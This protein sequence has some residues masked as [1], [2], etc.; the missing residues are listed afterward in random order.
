[1]LL[2]PLPLPWPSARWCPACL[3][4]RMHPP[5]NASTIPLPWCRLAETSPHGEALF[6]VAA[7]LRVDM[8]VGNTEGPYRQAKGDH[9]FRFSLVYA[10]PE[11]VLPQVEELCL[12][13]HQ[14]SDSKEQRAA[15]AEQMADMIQVGAERGCPVGAGL[16]GAGS[17]QLVVAAY[18]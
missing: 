8:Q 11:E 9:R 17:W 2:L 10:S 6:Q 12:L 4:G 1:M 16:V 7:S 13:A 14:G 18:C 3:P 5:F 15:A